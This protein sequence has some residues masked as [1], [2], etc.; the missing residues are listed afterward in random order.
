M[1]FPPRHANHP[2]P[3]P[4]FSGKTS[5]LFHYARA[6]AA[7]GGGR[8]AFVLTTRARADEA[9][10]LLPAGV[11]KDDAAYGAVQMK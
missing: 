4:P 1:R 3:P 8:P 10:P 9:P 2:S 5:L 7:A 11:A 6:A